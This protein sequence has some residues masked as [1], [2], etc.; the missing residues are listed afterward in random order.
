MPSALLSSKTSQDYA[1][2][3]DLYRVGLCCASVCTAM[4]HMNPSN[5][6]ANCDGG[7]VTFLVAGRQRSKAF[8]EPLLRLP[9]DLR[10]LFAE[11]AT[12][13]ASVPALYIRRATARCDVP[14]PCRPTVNASYHYHS[15]Q[16]AGPGDLPEP[17]GRPYSL[18]SHCDAQLGDWICHLF[19]TPTCPKC[20]HPLD[21]PMVITVPEM[22]EQPA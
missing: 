4:A 7:H 2:L 19:G 13:A 16:A 8:V 9:G 15:C 1:A 6:R 11:P 17:G 10:G 3:S 5:S 21:V 12:F 14:E 22:P 18:G 20:G